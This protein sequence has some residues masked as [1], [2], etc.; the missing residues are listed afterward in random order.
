MVT[1]KE[2]ATERGKGEGAGTET[3]ASGVR[4]KGTASNGDSIRQ[5]NG[6]PIT[7]TCAR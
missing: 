4:E 5:P 6:G 1:K 7:A 3:G 2:S